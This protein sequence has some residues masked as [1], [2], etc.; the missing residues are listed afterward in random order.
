MQSLMRLQSLLTN[1][2]VSV[3]MR[4]FSPC[5]PIKILFIDNW[6]VDSYV[7]I[8]GLKPVSTFLPWLDVIVNDEDKCS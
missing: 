3:S 6:K 4:R 7:L 8:I 2:S 5:F 1:F